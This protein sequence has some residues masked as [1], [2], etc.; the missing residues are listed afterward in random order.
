MHLITGEGQNL[1][2]NKPA[3]ICL[4]GIDQPLFSSLRELCIGHD[5]LSSESY[6]SPTVRLFVKPLYS[7]VRAVSRILGHG[8]ADATSMHRHYDNAD[9]IK[10]SAAVKKAAEKEVGSELSLVTALTHKAKYGESSSWHNGYYSPY[11]YN[12]DADVLSVWVPLQSITPDT[13][14]SFRFWYDKSIERI[15]KQLCKNRWKQ[16]D[17][18]TRGSPMDIVNP[19][20]ELRALYKL[21][22]DSDSATDKSRCTCHARLGEAILFNEYWPHKTSKWLGDGVRLSIVLRFVKKGTGLNRMRLNKRKQALKLD[23]DGWLQY[24]AFISK[25]EE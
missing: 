20:N 14:S 16:L 3:I 11:I 19:G 23:E 21:A 4:D 24:C 13:G 2:L 12:D 5:M 25:I 22:R 18:K 8:L 7:L 1:Q 10:L 17:A 6:V 15:S 9:F